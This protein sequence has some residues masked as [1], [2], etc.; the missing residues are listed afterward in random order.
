MN[1]PSH[2]HISDLHG[3]SRLVLTGIGEIIDL[4]E[5][6]HRKILCLPLE[7]GDDATRGTGGITGMVYGRVRA[8]TAVVSRWSDAALAPSAAMPARKL[9]TAEREAVLAALNGLVGDHLAASANSLAIPMRLRVD[10]QPLQLDRN[11]LAAALPQ[12]GGKLLILVHG[13]CRCDLQWRRGGHDHGAALARDLGY[14]PLYVHYNSGRHVSVNGRE[15]SALL[16]SAVEQWPVPVEEVAILAHSMGG[17]VSRSACYYAKAARH[18]WIRR[19]RHMVFLGTPH[20]GAPLARGGHWLVEVLGRAAYTAP[21]ARLGRI[22]SAGITD[23]H[24][25][26]LLDEDWMECN[27]FGH[28][29]DN[30][31]RV[32]LPRGVKCYAVAGSTGRRAG[33]LRERLLGDGLVPLDAALGK[34]QERSRSLSFPQSRQWVAYGIHHLDLLGRLEVYERIRDWLAAPPPKS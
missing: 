17:L 7:E 14:T 1:K 10:G 30:R 32:P 25:G 23:L 2:F 13:L 33:D 4:V 19:L 12:A 34:H 9:S 28:G 8:S 29:V 24:Y 27:R 3:I 20:H 15:F 31:R 11:A 16:E 18:S 22:R 6:L 26:N 21:F 5:M